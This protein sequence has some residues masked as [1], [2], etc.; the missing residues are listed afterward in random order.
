M[1]LF[2]QPGYST[3][4]FVEADIR[5]VLA[6]PVREAQ[7]NLPLQCS[8]PLVDAVLMERDQ[9]A[10]VPL[11]NYTLQPLQEVTLTVQTAQGRGRDG[12]SALPTD[13]WNVG[14][15]GRSS[16]WRATHC[17]P[18]TARSRNRSWS[19][20]SEGFLNSK[21]WMLK[22]SVNATPCSGSSSRNTR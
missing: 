4:V 14:A 18:S 11:A 13:A 2:C 7:V 8:V 9:G 6:L 22:S 19:P 15:A 16:R 20:V 12:D 17:C 21:K 3:T 5:Q 10:V 1:A